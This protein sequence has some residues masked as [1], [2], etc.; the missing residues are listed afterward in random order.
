MKTRD[1][2]AMLA[3][4]SVLAVLPAWADERADALV[5]MLEGVYRTVHD[6]HSPD[7]PQ[8]VDRRHRVLAPA[9]GEHV[10]Y[11]QLNSGPEQR[12]Y[13]Q[14]LLVIEPDAASGL[15]RQRTMSFRA[16]ARFADRFDD[17]ALFAAL[18]EEDVVNELPP[19]CL[20]L[21]RETRR[22]WRS[23]LDPAR[24][25]IFSSRHQDYRHIEAE[26]DLGPQSLGQAERGFDGQGRQLFGTPPGEMLLL[27][28]VSAVPAQGPGT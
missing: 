21:W 6:T 1:I 18:T 24:C 8:L 27:E 19:D 2:A 14:R 11:W 12:I 20:P 25:R 3:A 16:P 5:A 26:V 17:A 13:R 22:G 28:R 10:L 4:M 23:Y 9:L 15:L 7:S